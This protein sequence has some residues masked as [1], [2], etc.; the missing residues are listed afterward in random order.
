MELGFE[1][2]SDHIIV[3]SVI[4]ADTNKKLIQ[5]TIDPDKQF[6]IIINEGGVIG[7]NENDQT[8]SKPD[9]IQNI[10]LQVFNSKR[11]V[12][13]ERAELFGNLKIKF[14]RPEKSTKT[15]KI[16]ISPLT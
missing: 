4:L 13:L 15:I 2:K 11:K 8:L 3:I 5:S 12:I 16:L 7:L 6:Q 14:S 9:T 10:Y 1:V